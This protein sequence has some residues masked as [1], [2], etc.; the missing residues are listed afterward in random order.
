MNG[1]KESDKHYEVGDNEKVSLINNHDSVTSEHD[2]TSKKGK[3]CDK[4]SFL[5]TVLDFIVCFTSLQASYLIWGMMQ[6]LIMDTHFNATPLNPSGKFPSATF[7][8]FSNRFLAIIVSAFA[9]WWYHGTVLSSAPLLSFTPCALSNTISSW[10]QYQA[11]SFVSFGLQ[12]IFK[13][14][15]IIPV[16]VMGTVLKGTRYSCVEYAEALLITAGVTIFS[17]SKSSRASA[18]GTGGAGAEAIGFLLLCVYVLA[19]SFTSQWQSRVYRDYGKVDSLQMMFGVN[20]SSIVLTSAAL[21]LS[22]ELFLVVEFLRYN[23]DALYYNV[24]TAITSTTGQFAIF[25]TIRRF[26]PIVFTVI[27]TTRQMLSIV[28][29]NQIFGHSMSLQ[30]Y[31]GALLVFAA[32]G[33]STYRQMVA[34]TTRSAAGS[35]KGDQS[36]GSGGS[37]NVDNGSGGGGWVD[38]KQQGSRN[39]NTS[40]S[41]GNS[42]GSSSIGTS[43]STSARGGATARGGA[44]SLVELEGDS[45]V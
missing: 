21:L 35:S 45:N 15:K 1:A 41:S 2:A 27:M 44:S 37:P 9:C 22:G 34:T 38:D 43:G 42:G 10:G 19:D 20:V 3:S 6:E 32:I 30:S 8:V 18:N 13:S 36:R 11:L 39:G 17:L 28:L 31:L 12:T 29:S 4:P 33:M 16:M 7:C 24:I 25:Y 14:T 26:G 40:N 5:W 23:P